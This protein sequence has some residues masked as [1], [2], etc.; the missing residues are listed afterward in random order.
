MSTGKLFVIEGPDGSGKTTMC[1]NISKRL[2]FDSSIYSEVISLPNRFS[3]GY[4]KLREML[5][6]K[7]PTDILQSIMIANMKET[8]DNEIKPRLDAG[9]IVILD[10]WLVSTL[11]YNILNNGKLVTAMT[12]EG[13]T[14]SLRDISENYCKLT[15]YPDKIFYLSTPKCLVLEHARKRNS[16]E[17]NDQENNIKKIYNLY[18]DFYTAIK[19]GGKFP[20]ESK[21]YYLTE[22]ELNEERNRH[23]LIKAS[24]DENIDEA[25]MYNDMENTILQEIYSSICI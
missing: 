22:S 14:I 6:K 15:N 7:V 16:N 12:K 18:N 21:A 19:R 23:I 5:T 10:R 9:V 4:D 24:V 8:F 25:K 11:I 3:F 20:F 13:D 2:L 17:I 1:K